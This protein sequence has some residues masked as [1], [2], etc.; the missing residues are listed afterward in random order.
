MIIFRLAA[1][2]GIHSRHKGQVVH[3]DLAQDVALSALDLKYPAY[4]PHSRH[5]LVSA[6]ALGL[7]PTHR[8]S[9]TRALQFF[10]KDCRA[11]S[12]PA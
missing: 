6:Q 8:A 10:N 5:S 1:T 9:G 11:Y 2:I 7:V 4:K 12:L 3:C